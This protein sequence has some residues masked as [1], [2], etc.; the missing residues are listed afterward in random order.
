[1]S[2]LCVCQLCC[3]LSSR[4]LVLQNEL[5]QMHKARAS[6]L[7]IHRQRLN[8]TA[9]QL[10]T[11]LSTANNITTTTT[12]KLEPHNNQANSSLYASLIDGHQHIND[13]MDELS[14]ISPSPSSPSPLV[15]P[16]CR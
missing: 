10:N 3:A 7:E 16:S 1:M 11:L 12:T 8:A 15:P 9:K 14:N 4:S 13:M 5:D 6:E 2:S